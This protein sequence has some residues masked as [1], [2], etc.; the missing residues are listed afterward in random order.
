[1]YRMREG[2]THEEDDCLH[3]PGWYDDN[4]TKH[5]IVQNMSGLVI[6]AKMYRPIAASDQSS[7]TASR[8]PLIDHT[9]LQR[10]LILHNFE[11]SNRVII[12]NTIIPWTGSST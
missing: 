11:C 12:T 4:S 9:I 2:T 7:E 1:M 6:I 3:L 8:A 10:V 5:I